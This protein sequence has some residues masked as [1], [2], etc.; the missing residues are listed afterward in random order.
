MS[1]ISRNVWAE[2][3]RFFVIFKLYTDNIPAI[4]SFTIL[5]SFPLY[6]SS[7]KKDFDSF[8]HLFYVCAHSSIFWTQMSLIIWKTHKVPVTKYDLT[9]ECRV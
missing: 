5:D 8:S 7:C 1:N 9:F 6:V 2:F 3:N 4:N